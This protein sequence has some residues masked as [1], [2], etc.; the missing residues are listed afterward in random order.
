MDWV[1]GI[2]GAVLAASSA[3]WLVA[4]WRRKEFAALRSHPPLPPVAPRY[5]WSDRLQHYWR[6]SRRG[7]HALVLIAVSVVVGAS[8][9]PTA[10]ASDV[11]D[12]MTFVLKLIMYV[13]LL[14]VIAGGIDAANHLRRITADPDWRYVRRSSEQVFLCSCV[15]A[16]GVLQLG[17]L[18]ISQ[19]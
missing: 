6:L 10:D 7:S 1:L 8:L 18:L 17:S 3:C 14:T 11:E 4:P 13:V 12:W 5:W 2:A 15:F 9:S 19:I 16:F